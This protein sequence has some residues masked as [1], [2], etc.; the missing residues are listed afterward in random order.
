MTGS[1]P[2]FTERRKA[3]GK[4]LKG[5]ELG[6]GITQQS[7]GLY[8][9]R[10]TDVNG[11]RKT[12]R[13]RKLQECRQ[14]LAN[15]NENKR[16][17]IVT[18]EIRMNDWYKQWME[19]K[20]K[21]V[22]ENTRISY[23]VHYNSNI[24]PVLGE[25]FLSDIKPAHC[26][27]VFID[28]AKKEMSNNSM[29]STRAVL[30]NILEAAMENGLISSNPCTKSIKT[31]IGK[32]EKERAA[33]TKEEQARFL[34]IIKGTRHENE[35]LFLLQTGLRI[36][37]LV[38]LKWGDVDFTNR[39]I[40]VNR[41]MNYSCVAKRWIS[42]EPKTKTGKRIVP[43]TE[44]ALQILKDRKEKNAALKKV[45]ME[46]IEFIFLSESGELIPGYTYY[47]SMVSLCQHNHFR[48]ISPHILRHTFATRCIE[49][50]MKPR[51]LQEILGHSNIGITMNTYVHITEDEKKNEIKKIAY[52]LNF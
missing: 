51:T 43:L 20:E 8:V 12:K 38:G 35:M 5:R 28:M 11:R 17:G 9:A 25:M 52:A 19:I 48:Q 34:K 4:N 2:L 3:M 42:G 49:A 23:R 15:E 39:T 30:H 46:Y 18:Q 45:N 47:Y 37:E 41:T 22:R 36:G 10:C 16:Q 7:D 31:N 33:L 24:E 27:K 40:T 6:V 26:Q 32:S 21:T 1:F 29:S 44:K 50:G 14:W 13:F